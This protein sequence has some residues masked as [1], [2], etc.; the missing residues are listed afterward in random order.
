MG[1]LIKS[2]D[3]WN[4][5]VS[6][7]QQKQQSPPPIKQKQVVQPTQ[8]V[9]KNNDDDEVSEIGGIYATETMVQSRIQHYRIA[10]VQAKKNGNMEAARQYLREFKEMEKMLPF[11]RSG[12]IKPKI[13]DLP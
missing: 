6:K 8:S 1:T 9:M 10:C 2:N 13:Q 7:P 4:L 12:K 5:N 3:L 11:I